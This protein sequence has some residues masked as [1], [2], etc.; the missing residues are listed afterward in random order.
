MKTENENITTYVDETVTIIWDKEDGKLIVWLD[1][2]EKFISHDFS[3]SV[4]E[5]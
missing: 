3:H 5:D 2:G 1:N 4:V